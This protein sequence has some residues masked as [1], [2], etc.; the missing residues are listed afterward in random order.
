MNN[1]LIDSS[2]RTVEW[3]NNIVIMIDQTK[4]PNQLVFVKYDDYNQVANA[5]RTLVVRGAPAIGVSGAFGLALA[6]LQEN[7]KTHVMVED[8]IEACHNGIVSWEKPSVVRPILLRGKDDY[9]KT[10]E[11]FD[12]IKEFFMKNDIDFKEIHSV[13]GNILTKV[14]SLIYMLDYVSIYRAILSKTDPSPV[15]SIDYIKSRI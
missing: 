14:M 2:L 1:N 12:I 6:S 7:A 3:K 4:L 15:S 9:I 8:V 11:R 13:S 10:K 5:I